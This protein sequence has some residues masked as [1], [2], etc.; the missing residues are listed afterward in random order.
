MTTRAWSYWS[1]NKLGIL[2]DYLPAFTR[3]CKKYPTKAYV[4]LMAGNIVNTSRETGEEFDGS[5]LIAL[6][7]DPPFSHLIFG[8]L[9]DKARPLADYLSENFPEKNPKVVPGDCNQTIDT[10][11]GHLADVRSSPM[12]FFIDQHA[13]EIKWETLTKIAKFRRSRHGKAEMWILTS[14][15]L[16]ARA[17]APLATNSAD[18]IQQTTDFYGTE[19]W[20][21][22]YAAR[23]GGLIDGGQARVELINLLRFRLENVL[24]YKHTLFIPMK[25]TNG[26][27]IYNMVFATDHYVGDKIMRHCYISAAEREPRMKAEATWLLQEQKREASGETALFD[28]KPEYRAS[29]VKD[30]WKPVPT[31]DPSSASWWED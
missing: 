3:A 11:L 10:I 12:F 6:K 24:G 28:V 30:L 7:T 9:P 17:T 5:P 31:W 27:D 15:A 21:R 20:K 8:E 14:P 13:T 25:M 2:Q 4:D 23:D 16:T 18:Q 22:V 26:I 19:D 1:R 29:D